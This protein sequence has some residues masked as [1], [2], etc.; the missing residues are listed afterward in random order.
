MYSLD[1]LDNKKQIAFSGA[2][3]TGHLTLGNY[4]GA[5]KRWVMM[6]TEYDCIFCVVDL[7]SITVPQ[8]AKSLRENTRKN[9]ALYLAAG[10][11]AGKS[12]IFQQSAVGAHSELAWILGC[13]T[14]TGW[15]NRMIQFKEKSVGK[16]ESVSVG[17]Y[18]YPILMAAD[19]LLY[20]T[21][22]VPV[23]EDQKQHVELTR[24]IAGAFNRYFG[25]DYFVL[26]QAVIDANMGRVMSLR[27]ATKKMSKSDPVD[28]SR[29]NLT[30]NMDVI[31]QKIKKAKTDSINGI[32]Y[33]VEKR[34]ELSNL[35]DI[36]CG[37]TNTT[38]EKALQEFANIQTSQ[39]KSILTDA[40]IEKLVPL[41]NKAR[42][43]ADN[44]SYVNEIIEEGN[45]KARS[46]A[47]GT[48]SD[49]KH[50]MGF[51]MKFGL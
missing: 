5:I 41:C 25:V 21:T 45:Y 42:D 28:A 23:G 20:K 50:M 37:L 26:P 12:I 46:I 49:V 29:I 48:L 43:I 24:D 8:N 34:P 39:F 10:V 19:I 35:L 38:L 2:Q 11:D 27:D 51:D 36:Y 3:P 13:F 16:G 14:Q 17:L 22:H 30:D 47:S 1:S 15:L 7:H 4:L 40:L 44:N 9:V 33:D 18:T 6:Q 32:W 31:A